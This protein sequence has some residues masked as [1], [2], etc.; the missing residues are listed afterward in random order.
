MLSGSP[1]ALRFD[2]P[3]NDIL[4][5]GIGFIHTATSAVLLGAIGPAVRPNPSSKV[6]SEHT[7]S[8]QHH[9]WPVCHGLAHEGLRHNR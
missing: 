2:E 6:I 7:A 4:A 3:G 9:G 5:A 8:R 1:V